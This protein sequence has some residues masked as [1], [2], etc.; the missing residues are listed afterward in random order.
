MEMN[1]GGIV[2]KLLIVRLGYTYVTKAFA[3]IAH[4]GRYHWHLLDSNS[5]TTNFIRLSTF[6]QIKHSVET[7]G[8]LQHSAEEIDF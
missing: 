1:N 8:I 2:V 7:I 5:S 4:F 3:T 6:V